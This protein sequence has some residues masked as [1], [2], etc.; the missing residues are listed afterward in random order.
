[1]TFKTFIQDWKASIKRTPPDR[2]LKISMQGYI[3]QSIGII[4]ACIFLFKN[5]FWYIVLA[6]CFSLLN[7]YAG[8]TG[9]YQQYST[10]MALKKELNII[11]SEDKSPYRNKVKLIQKELGRWPAWIT[12]ITAIAPFIY[13]YVFYAG[14]LWYTLATLTF[15]IIYYLLYFQLFYRIAR[16]KSPEIK[17]IKIKVA[18]HYV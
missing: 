8:F 5:G 15:I 10:I 1:M 16:R 3:W 12:I 11:D 9:A 17:E 4:I 6:L 13:V 14:I 18:P 2:L 7:N